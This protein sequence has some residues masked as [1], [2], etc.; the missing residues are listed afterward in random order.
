MPG[1]AR[2]VSAGPRRPSGTDQHAVHPLRGLLLGPADRR[3]VAVQPSGEEAG[4]PDAGRA[5][6]RRGEV[7]ALAQVE[8][9]VEAAGDPAATGQVVAISIDAVDR[10][11]RRGDDG[12]DHV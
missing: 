3:E 7:V 8:V 2:W 1:A 12:V 11:V 9:A 5:L 6:G 4:A 10:L